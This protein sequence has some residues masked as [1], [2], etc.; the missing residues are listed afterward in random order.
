VRTVLP[1]VIME[2]DKR[3]V[4]LPGDAGYDD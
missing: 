4:L 1:R 2:G 3:R